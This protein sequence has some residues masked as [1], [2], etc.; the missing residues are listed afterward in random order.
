MP[1]NQELRKVIVGRTVKVT[2]T[3]P[4]SVLVV[5]DDQSKM[6]IKTA[7]PATI[8]PSCKVKAVHEAKA[9]LEYVPLIYTG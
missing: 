8:P 2:T 4:G 6:K 9:E 1:R 3:E 7:G 5:F